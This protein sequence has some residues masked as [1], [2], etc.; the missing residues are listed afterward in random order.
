MI[1]TWARL[2]FVFGRLTV[3]ADAVARRFACCGI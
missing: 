3:F 2:V 1:R